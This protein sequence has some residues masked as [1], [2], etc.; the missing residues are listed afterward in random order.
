ME[1]SKKSTKSSTLNRADHLILKALRLNPSKSEA[2]V[3][4]AFN[5]SEEEDWTATFAEKPSV[6]IV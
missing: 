3:Q 5:K 6:G 4:Y 1:A 2:C